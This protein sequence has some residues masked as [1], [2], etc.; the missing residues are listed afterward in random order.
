MEEVEEEEEQ[1]ENGNPGFDSFLDEADGSVA[2]RGEKEKK[3]GQVG[4]RGR[5]RGHKHDPKGNA[6]LR[7]MKRSV[8]G[9]RVGKGKAAVRVPFFREGKKSEAT[10]CEN[11]WI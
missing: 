3:R 5:E 7:I 4:R 11:G 2:A 6:R 1:E 9:E 10:R 8:Q